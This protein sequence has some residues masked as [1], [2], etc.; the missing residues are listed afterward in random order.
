VRPQPA[1]RQVGSLEPTDTLTFADAIAGYLFNVKS[2]SE[3]SLW[4]VSREFHYPVSP[5]NGLSGSLT[6]SFGAIQEFNQM[7]VILEAIKFNHDPTSKTTGAFNIRRNETRIVTVPEW[8]RDSC[9]NPECSP[10]AYAISTLPATITIQASFVC[11]DPTAT[12]IRVRALDSHSGAPTNVLGDIP[13]H[14]IPLSEGVSGYQNIYLKNAKISQGGVGVSDV[15]WRWQFLRDSNWTDLER[16]SHRIYAVLA[17]PTAPW[18]PNSSDSSNA[19]IPWTEVLEYACRWASGA[20]HVDLAAGLVTQNVNAL[21]GIRV[22]YFKDSSYIPPDSKNFDCTKFL[23]RLSG[24]EGNGPKVSCYDCATVV[25]SFSNILGAALWQSIMGSNFY[26]NHVLRIGESIEDGGN[27]FEHE[28]AWTR[29]ATKDDPLFD[30]CLHVDG[31]ECPGSKPFMSLLP[32]NIRFGERTDGGYRYRL[33]AETAFGEP[34]EAIPTRKDHRIIGVANLK[35]RVF[36]NAALHLLMEHYDFAAWEHY[37]ESD[38]QLLVW[39]FFTSGKE[40]L[41]WQPNRVDAFQSM[42]EMPA[43]NQAFWIIQT[44]P[45]KAVR[46]DLLECASLSDAHLTL[47]E[48]LGGFHVL[49]MKPQKSVSFADRGDVVVG[50]V[51]FADSENSSF[52]FTRGN[53]VVALRNDGASEASLAEFANSLDIWLKTRPYADGET[54]IGEMKHFRFPEGQFQVGDSVRLELLPGYPGQKQLMY[55]FFALSGQFFLKERKPVYRPIASGNQE[56]FIFATDA[57]GEIRMQTLTI[58]IQ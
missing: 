33:E 45:T 13:E 10:V 11:D 19:Q 55:R 17:P 38:E 50:D 20:R 22:T 54:F 18:Q 40:V 41:D 12:S 16:T 35:K 44:D 34:C 31:D 36:S 2:Q 21:G 8:R 30:A 47:L 58:D 27:F 49:D 48:V 39:R 42:P 57:G 25:S 5:G 37:Q 51:A 9:F 7:S 6:I 24:G 14:D 26:I 15:I 29:N 4:E 23:D 56:I 43:T 53:V 32:I 46:V 1:S 3:L 52:L 28:V